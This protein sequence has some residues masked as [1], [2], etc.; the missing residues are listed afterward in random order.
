MTI[1]LSN[2]DQPHHDQTV[3]DLD[4]ALIP[5]PSLEQLL[6][7]GAHGAPLVLLLDDLEAFFYFSWIGAG[8]IAA[9]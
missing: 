6:L 9:Q 2:D 3:D 5:S 8:A 1:R 4:A 7:A